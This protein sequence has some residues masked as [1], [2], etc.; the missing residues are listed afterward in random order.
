MARTVNEILTQMVAEKNAQSALSGLNSPSTVSK[1]NLFLYVVAVCIAVHEQIIDIRNAAVEAL[2]VASKLT[3]N[4]GIKYDVLN[5]FQYS[6][7]NPQVLIQS[8]FKP[9]YAIIDPNLRI[10]TR[11]SVITVMPGFIDVK[12]AKGTTSPAPLSGPEQSALSTFLDVNV[13]PGVTYNLVSTD[14]DKIYVQADVMYSGTY[15]PVIAANVKQALTDF[16]AS[17]SSDTN[18]NGV[19]L[20]S[21]V[22]KII[23]GVPGV[24]DVVIKKVYA[25]EDTAV[26]AAGTKVMDLSLGVNLASYQMYAGW[27]IEENTAGYTLNDSLNFLVG[28]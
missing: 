19:L 15:A 2:V 23:K 16:Y 9:T 8:A 10:V 27:G 20:V 7:T 12:V 28:G 4:A 26:F 13:G 6:A 17:L 5:L 3:T 14:A 22:E 1:W 24:L 18:L 11:C 25:R 21:D